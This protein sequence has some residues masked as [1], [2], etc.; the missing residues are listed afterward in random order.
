MDYGWTR[1]AACREFPTELFFSEIAG[2]PGYTNEVKTLVCEGCPVRRQCLAAALYE[3]RE[4]TSMRYGVR[5][6]LTAKERRELWSELVQRRTVRRCG[7]DLH[8]IAEGDREC[9]ECR[10]I[11]RERAKQKAI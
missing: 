6:G 2:S 9:K 8:I 5:G 4:Y 10:R 11:Y 7:R 3:E 1:Y